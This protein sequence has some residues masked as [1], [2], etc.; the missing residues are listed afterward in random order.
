MSKELT[1]W[2]LHPIFVQDA[3]NLLFN[4]FYF[5]EIFIYRYRSQL[6]GEGLRC[7]ANIDQRLQACVVVV[8]AKLLQLPELLES[9]SLFFAL[10]VDAFP[11]LVLVIPVSR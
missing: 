5:F 7:T 9:L 3:S 1:F 11:A 8:L 10:R 4:V 6:L 2:I